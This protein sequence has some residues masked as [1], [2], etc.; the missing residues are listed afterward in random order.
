MHG[1]CNA[2]NSVRFRKE[3]PHHPKGAFIALFLYATNLPFINTAM[4]KE[5]TQKLKKQEKDINDLKKMVILLK[6]SNNKL[7]AGYN[8]NANKIRMMQADLLS[9]SSKLRRQ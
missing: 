8:R 3:A 1:T 9:L 5:L 2:D 4:D 6:Q 7:Q